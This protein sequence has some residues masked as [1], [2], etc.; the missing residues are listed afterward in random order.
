[1]LIAYGFPRV[2][3]PDGGLPVDEDWFYVRHDLN[4][5]VA[6][7]SSVV[8]VWSAGLHRVRLSQVI[9]SEKEIVDEGTNVCAYWCP[10][11]ATLA[12]LVSHV[13]RERPA[14]MK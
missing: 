9:R 8:Q 1:M 6:V 7:S 5:I 12:V 13:L 14:H 3:S 11:K 4:Y 10:T 2:L